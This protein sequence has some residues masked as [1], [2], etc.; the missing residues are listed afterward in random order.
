MV[1][2][3][4]VKRHGETNHRHRRLLCARRERPRCRATEQRRE[5]AAFQLRDHSMTSSAR[6]EQQSAVLRLLQA[7][8]LARNVVAET[9]PGHEA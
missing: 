4:S 9:S 1:S 8:M 2:S 3:H 7:A 6:P 5:F